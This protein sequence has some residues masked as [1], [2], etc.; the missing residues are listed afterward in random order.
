M[1]SK[2]YASVWFEK[3]NYT[4]FFKKKNTNIQKYFSIFILNLL[5]LFTRPFLFNKENNN[6]EIYTKFSF[7]FNE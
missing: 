5:N 7:E 3:K 4:I 2:F 1:S 6:I